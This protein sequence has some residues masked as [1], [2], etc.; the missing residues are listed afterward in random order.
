MITTFVRGLITLL[1]R[2]YF[3]RIERFHPERVPASGPV[4]FVSNHPGSITDA[5]I[6]GTS[7][8]RLVHFVATVQLFKSTA[9]ASFLRRCG[10]IPI[11]RKADDP[12]AMRSVAAT[13]EACY[14]V[15]EHDGAVGIF[16]EGL[17]YDDSQLKEVKSGAARMAI[18]LESRHNGTLGLRI[19]PVGLTY[20]AKERYRSD[21]LV[22]FGEPIDVAR[23][24]PAQNSDRKS[25]IHAL[26]ALIEQR[27][28]ALI[29]DL[30]DLEHQRI[31]AAVKRL[32]RDKLRLGNLLIKES[33]APQA[34]DL[35]LTQ[36]IS[37]GLRFFEK[38]F[39]ERYSSF[40][41]HL[42]RYERRLEQFGV[43]DETIEHLESRH[44]VARN[45]G[46]TARIVALAPIAFYGWVHRI[47]PALLVEWA[48]G[49]FT[50]KGLRKAQTAHASMLAG[51]VGFTLFY[52]ACIAAVDALL[53]WHV[54]LWYAVSLPVAGLIA[55]LHL[56]WMREEAADLRAAT[57]LH[58]L[59]LAK[60]VL[61]TMR[62]RLIDELTELR[63][64]YRRS[65]LGVT[66]EPVQEV[67]PLA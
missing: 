6:V 36:Q 1:L 62:E 60:R 30:P 55:H 25:A 11:N 38:N 29:V 5:F 23:H 41:D 40:V 54:A 52:G 20:S 19:A 39:P 43:S 35:V 10:V 17:S 37:Q 66:P 21:V 50:H 45:V 63:A 16:P 33:L 7:V 13:F 14:D 24:L 32:Y 28:R 3:R 64:E 51:L 26:T 44:P 31:V 8:P 2:L 61:V 22:H 58:R 57:L 59:P 27:L 4:L 12:R 42:H 65:A 49:H 46:A 15:L 67:A 48:V 34:E 18:E 47:V 9:L 56:Q 53:G